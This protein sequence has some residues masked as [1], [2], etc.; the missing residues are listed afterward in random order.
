MQK[1]HSS[2]T[3]KHKSIYTVCKYQKVTQD[4]FN[5]GVIPYDKSQNRNLQQLEIPEINPF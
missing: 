2:K 1:A 4:Y 3:Y 5:R